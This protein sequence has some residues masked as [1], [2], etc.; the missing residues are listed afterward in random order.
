MP[1]TIHATILASGASSTTQ[2]YGPHEILCEAGVLW[3]EI[4]STEPQPGFDVEIVTPDGTAVSCRPQSQK[5][6]ADRSINDVHETDVVLIASGHVDPRS[7]A[8]LR[9]TAGRWI[10]KMYSRGAI[11][12]GIARGGFLLADTG[13]LDRRVATTHWADADRF[14]ALFPRVKL[15]PERMLTEDAG[16]RL[17]CS[18]GGYAFADLALRIVEIFFGFE[19]AYRCSRALMLDPDRGTQN[20]YATLESQMHHSDD[21]VA[22]AQRFIHENY[23]APLTIADLAKRT[24]MSERNFKRRFKRSTGDLPLE[25]LQ[26]Y[27]VDVA[28]RLLTENGSGASVEEV[29]GKVGYD[30]ISHFRRIF[31]RH[32]GMS[33]NEYF[34]RNRAQVRSRPE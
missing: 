10:T 28:R 26:R 17:L 6:F 27:R 30:D 31:A 33:V 16:G 1:K 5:I 22:V 20:R 2:V 29:C 7:L 13:L 24:G 4:Q 11:V 12:A 23:A 18:G 8:D 14:R 15:Q 25:Y 34:R 21:A 32:A 9:P 19:T 3:N